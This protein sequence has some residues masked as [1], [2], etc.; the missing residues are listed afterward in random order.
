[1]NIAE[2]VL[3]PDDGFMVNVNFTGMCIVPSGV[4]TCDPGIVIF[5]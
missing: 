3:V 4:C 2:G 5:Y 1:M